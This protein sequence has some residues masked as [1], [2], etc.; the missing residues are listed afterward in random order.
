MAPRPRRSV[1][2]RDTCSRL[3]STRVALTLVMF[4]RVPEPSASLFSTLLSS[5]Y[6]ASAI[7]LGVAVL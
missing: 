4:V 5:L 6:V 7:S 3:T 1:H 2:T